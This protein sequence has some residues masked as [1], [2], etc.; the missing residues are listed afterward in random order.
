MAKQSGP[1][2]QNGDLIWLEATK[3]RNAI[4][5]LENKWECN[6]VGG[7]KCNKNANNIWSMATKSDPRRQNMAFGS[8]VWQ[9]KVWIQSG[10]KLL[11]YPQNNG[12][13]YSASQNT[14]LNNGTL[15]SSTGY[16]ATDHFSSNLPSSLSSRH[17][18]L[19]LDTN[20]L[21]HCSSDF[22]FFKIG[23]PILQKSQVP[24]SSGCPVRVYNKPGSPSQSGFLPKKTR[25]G[26]AWCQFTTDQLISSPI[27]KLPAFGSGTLHTVHRCIHLFQLKCIEAIF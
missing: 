17:L 11:C 4:Y 7:K 12:T 8:G 13:G 15:T 6:L 16:S 19:D 24:R 14:T 18:K 27:H 2:Q 21:S 26:V 25:P 9:Q 3:K 20:F 5:Y 1:R 10:P 23:N 22:H